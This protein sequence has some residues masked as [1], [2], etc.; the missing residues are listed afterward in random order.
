[1]VDINPS[2]PHAAVS[3]DMECFKCKR[4][5]EFIVVLKCQVHYC[6]SPCYKTS[7]R[8][9]SICTSR[10]SPGVIIFMDNSNIWIEAKKNAGLKSFGSNKIEDPRLYTIGYW[11]IN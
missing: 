3:L 2:F 7:G 10:A 1:M 9:C 8:E 4:K 6:C 11:E 5:H